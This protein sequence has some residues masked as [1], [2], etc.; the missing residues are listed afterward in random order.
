LNTFEADAA[1]A[2]SDYRKILQE[3]LPPFD[4]ALQGANI[5]PVSGSAP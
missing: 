5:A 2:D 3:D 4:Q 1:G